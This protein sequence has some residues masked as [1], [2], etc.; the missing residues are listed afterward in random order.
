MIESAH[1]SLPAGKWHTM[2]IVQKGNHFECYLNG[3]KYLSGKDNH[4]KNAGGVGLWTKADA[5][6]YFDNFK[7]KVEK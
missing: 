4:F 1:V 6:T 7:V 3:K 2:K 5:V